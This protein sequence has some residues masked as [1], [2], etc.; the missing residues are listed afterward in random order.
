MDR[1]KAK[2]GLLTATDSVSQGFLL[3]KKIV[4]VEVGDAREAE[5]FGTPNA[6][7]SRHRIS[8]TLPQACT[9]RSLNKLTVRHARWRDLGISLQSGRLRVKGPR[10]LRPKTSCI[11]EAPR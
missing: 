5:A 1:T 3:L 8:V 4:V 11:V 6:R 10:A 2:R 7:S 9:S